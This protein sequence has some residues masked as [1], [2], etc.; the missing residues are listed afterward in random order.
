MDSSWLCGINGQLFFFNVTQRHFFFFLKIEEIFS[1]FSQSFLNASN[2]LRMKRKIFISIKNQN[3]SQFPG[4]F[5]LC[6]FGLK[7]NQNIVLSSSMAPT[8]CLLYFVYVRETW[9]STINSKH[10]K[11]FFPEDRS[12]EKL[13]KKWSKSRY[14]E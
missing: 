2:A 10:I 5:L 7:R 1:I 8:K 13:E 6:V 3:W 11:Q 9:C 12:K 14:V 4:T